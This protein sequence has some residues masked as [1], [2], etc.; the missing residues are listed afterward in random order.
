VLGLP[1]TGTGGSI[2]GSLA[3]PAVLVGLA[4]VAVAGIAF[5]GMLRFGR[6]RTPPED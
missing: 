2:S 6:D 1:N 5:G 4:L 3:V